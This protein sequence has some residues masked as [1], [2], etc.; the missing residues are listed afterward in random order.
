VSPPAV[1]RAFYL[2]AGRE[3]VYALLDAAQ[4]D[5]LAGA[6]GVLLCPLFGNDDLC[7]YRSRREWARTLASAGRPALRI[8]L[9]GTGDSGGGPYDPER[10]ETWT[11][12][13]T[14]GA[15]RLREEVGSG[16]VV[17]IGVGLG[18]LLAYRAASA[19]APIDDL[20]LWSVPA[21]G[22]T[23]VRQ[24]R[25]LARMEASHETAA[26]RDRQT[27]PPGALASAGFLLSAETVAELE[28]L[29]LTELQLP[30]AAGR[31]VLLLERDG[32]EVDARLRSCL[33]QSGAAVTL[34]P[35]PGYG[36]MV[37]PPQQSRPPIEVFAS[38]ETWLSEAPG[39]PRADT[40][41]QAS[42]TPAP[43]DG[44]GGESDTLDLTIDGVHVRETPLTI[45]HE[46]GRLVAVLAEAEGESSAGLCAVLLNAGA[47]RH[48]GP[49]RMWVE[50]ARRWAARGVPTLRIDLAGI[51][52][53]D[54]DAGTLEQ[55]E[56]LYVPRY[57]AQT[58][59]VLEALA[60]RG[61]PERFVLAGLCSGSYWALHAALCDERVAGAYMVN[62]RAMFWDWRIPRVRNARDLR[63]MI[64]AATWR[65]LLRGE[66][67]AARVRDIASGVLVAVRMMPRRSWSNLQ[68]ARLEH[69]LDRLERGGTELVWIFTAEEP[70]RYELK[71]SG[72]LEH[73]LRRPNVRVEDIPGPLTSHTL[74]PL[75]LQ[76]IVHDM[77]DAALE[78]QLQAAA[79]Q[80]PPA[81]EPLARHVE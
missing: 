42:A 16:R 41:G 54:G 34:A 24:L 1:A 25:V 66:I 75:P 56:G 14:T 80:R 32:L 8:D 37:T 70:L 6:V 45:E 3:P 40:H 28:A 35:G 23:F 59:E 43:A 30:R 46:E 60:A 55:D 50:I 17:A 47:L 20:V 10:L 33:E 73:M 12:A 49:N 31:R 81:G 52:D 39:G 21:R 58:L 18:G 2:T 74:E 62:P 26:E 51:G 61:L 71:R 63:K 15:S 65:K 67:R 44:R 57:V 38:V 22:R 9:P 72:G 4:P 69:A 78:R 36:R 64:R 27:I 48:I 19:G 5:S 7:S 77:L 79:A 76:R 68:D 13:V 29:D 53:S 11:D